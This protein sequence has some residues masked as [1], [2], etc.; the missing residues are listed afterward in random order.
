[1]NEARFVLAGFPVGIV[2]YSWVKRGNKKTEGE[3]AAPTSCYMNAS[4]GEGGGGVE[5]AT[6]GPAGFQQV[7]QSK[8]IEEKKKHLLRA[9]VLFGCTP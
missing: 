5:E 6:G 7:I 3:K 4:D 1:M 9:E 2:V 8:K